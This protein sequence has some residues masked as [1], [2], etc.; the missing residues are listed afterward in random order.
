MAQ[1]GLE[2]LSEYNLNMYY[3]IFTREK[4]NAQAEAEL[5][6]I[7]EENGRI[8]MRVWQDVY[9]EY[10]SNIG[11][12]SGICYAFIGILGAIC[13]M[14]MINTMIHSV[15]I[16]KKEIG[17]LQAVGLSDSQLLRMLQLEGLFYTVGTLLIAVVGGSLAG[18]PVFLWAKTQGIFNITNYHYPTKIAIILTVVLG[19]LQF[20]LTLSLG[21]IIK[22]DSLIHRIRFDN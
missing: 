16:R 7:V 2:K 1:E 21:K 5:K 17:I 19:M 12:T 3:H 14:N 11:M 10:Q 13:I 15:H 18:Y 22:R 20:V 8:Q 6:A 9:E 4:Y